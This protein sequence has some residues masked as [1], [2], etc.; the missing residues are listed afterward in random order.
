METRDEPSALGSALTARS[1][2]KVTIQLTQAI[3]QHEY[4][5]TVGAE[6]HKY[7]LSEVFGE[8]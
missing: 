1:G 5:A 3:I 2:Q 4:P 7:N 8:L 6:D